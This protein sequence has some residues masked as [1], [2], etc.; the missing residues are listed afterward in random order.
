MVYLFL[1]L[2]ADMGRERCNRKVEVKVRYFQ[3]GTE[4]SKE[5]RRQDTDRANSGRE[6]RDT[7]KGWREGM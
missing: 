2:W 1:H 7:G 4:I 6:G 5:H 3:E